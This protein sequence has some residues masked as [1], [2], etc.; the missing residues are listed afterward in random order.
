MDHRDVRLGEQLRD[1][2]PFKTAMLEQI[3]HMKAPSLRAD[4]RHLNPV[5]LYNTWKNHKAMDSVILPKLE[6]HKDRKAD[7]A[8]LVD[9]VL[10]DDKANNKTST[11]ERNSEIVQGLISNI[12]S[13]AFAGHDTTA[14][15][16]CWC[17]YNL[18]RY[19]SAM[20]K[21]Q[22]EHKQILGPDPRQA[23]DILL[24]DPQKIND[25]PYT[26]A[27]IKETLRTHAIVHSFRKGD[28]SLE[29]KTS[30]ASVSTDGFLI[31]IAGPALH[32]HPELWHKA[33]EFIPERWLVSKD[34]PL[35][36]P[37]H[38]WRPFEHGPLNCIG[39]ELALIEL[40]LL[41]VRL[42]RE[43]EMVPAWEKWDKLQ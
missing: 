21:L 40:K 4:A 23:S 2:S 20:A 9:L 39:Q 14:T 25:L 22:A 10:G 3:T 26:L 35:Y 37:P 13:F 29:L 36:P 41:L 12:K 18:S 34:D 1:D 24:Q 28:P 15:T 27:V 31:I 33:E 11:P 6:A 19:P 32:L 43:V 16:I 17:F 8:T 42:V 5:W 7:D 30:R 38:A